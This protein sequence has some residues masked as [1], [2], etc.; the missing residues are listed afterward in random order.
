MNRNRI[1]SCIKIKCGKQDQMSTPAENT[2]YRRRSKVDGQN[3]QSQVTDLDDT[4]KEIKRREAQSAIKADSHKQ[5]V[6]KKN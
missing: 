2:C 1:L 3:K 5:L 6:T 4:L